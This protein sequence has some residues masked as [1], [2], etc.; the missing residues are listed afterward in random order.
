MAKLQWCPDEEA[1]TALVDSEHFAELELRVLS[2]EEPEPPTAS[3]L[4]SV[5]VVEQYARTGLPS[6]EK[7]ARKYALEYLGSD[8]V[9]DMKDED[10]AIDI[11]AAIVPRLR[12]SSDTYVIFVGASDI[13]PE[14]GVSILCK[15]GKICVVTHSDFAYANYDWD[16]TSELDQLIG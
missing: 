13:D 15:N 14:H 1:W 9:D 7:L 11:H 10:F 6:T 12:D 8:E 4:K 2:D 3:Q 5:A 16:D